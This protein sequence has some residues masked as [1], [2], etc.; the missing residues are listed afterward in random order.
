M[1]SHLTDLDELSQKVK[2]FHSRNYIDEAIKSYRAG[3]YR[4]SLIS[5]WVAVCVDI[6]EKIKELA[7]T[8]DAAAVIL[9]DKLKAIDPSMQRQ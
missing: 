8:E 4:A 9:A 2:N 3:A 6:I 5:T 7:L 1:S